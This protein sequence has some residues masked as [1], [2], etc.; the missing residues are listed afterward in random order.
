[1]IRYHKG[2]FHNQYLLEN[3]KVI[4]LITSLFY[5]DI[6]ICCFQSDLRFFEYWFII[7]LL[8]ISILL[9]VAQFNYIIYP[10][11]TKKNRIY[12]YIIL[13]C[14]LFNMILQL[15]PPFYSSDN[16]IN[17]PMHLILIIV[18]FFAI[19]LIIYV[20]NRNKD[21]FKSIS[22]ILIIMVYMLITSSLLNISYQ[23]NIINNPLQFPDMFF[24]SIN[25]II[26]P[27]LLWLLLILFIAGIMIESVFKNYR[28]HLLFYAIRISDRS[29]WF[30]KIVCKGMCK[31]IA[32][33]MIK[34]L[35][36]MFF[37]NQMISISLIQGIIISVLCISDIVLLVFFLYQF[38]KDIKL[39]NVVVIGFIS[40]VFISLSTGILEDIIFL[41]IQNVQM[42]LGTFILLLILIISNCYALNHLDYY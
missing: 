6:L 41:R 12:F 40:L 26:V 18:L 39:F 16:F 4:V 22:K 15:I 29:Q 9:M 17:D 35:I 2:E 30:I 3:I 33:I 25:E 24:M 13:L 10:K 34:C 19:N 27:L 21:K 31:V 1:M 5:A 38:I 32:L 7:Y 11:L 8:S 36:D 28:A 23:G 42:I 14:E 20:I 37:Q